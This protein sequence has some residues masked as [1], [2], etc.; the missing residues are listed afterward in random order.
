M[1]WPVPAGGLQLATRAALSAGVAVA[2][3]EF[4]R[5]QYPLY[6]MI[7]AI[8]VTDLSPSHTRKLGL[9]R[10]AGSTLGATVGAAA[11]SFL[12]STPWSVGFSVLVAM[13]LSHALHLGDAAKVTGYVCGIVVLG[14]NDDSWSYSVY[15][16]AE[17]IVGVGVAILVSF[18][19]KLIPIDGPKKQDS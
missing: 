18:V 4:L 7:G 13:L 17:T 9:H 16:L 5:L 3:A 14:H 15:R 1:S 11:S 6:A 12:P 10:L 8:I 19:P 2:I